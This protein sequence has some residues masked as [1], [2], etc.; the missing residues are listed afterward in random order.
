MPRPSVVTGVRFLFGRGRLEAE[1][2]P[3]LSARATFRASGR[4]SGALPN[5]GRALHHRRTP[6]NGRGMVLG[7]RRYAAWT[8]DRSLYSGTMHIITPAGEDWLATATKGSNAAYV[9]SSTAGRLHLRRDG[10]KG[11]LGTSHWPVPRPSE[12]CR[13]PGEWT[14]HAHPGRCSRHVRSDRP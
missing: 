8:P 10:H 5:G 13:T 14:A 9:L 12:T 7:Y 6:E 1:A 2:V 4:S 3:S 11:G